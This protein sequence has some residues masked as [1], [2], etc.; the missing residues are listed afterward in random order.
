MRIDMSDIH[1]SRPVS[2]L[3]GALPSYVGYEE[4]WPATKPCAAGL[5][6]VIPVR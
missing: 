6:A 1:E 4:A 5:Y 3:I 2:R